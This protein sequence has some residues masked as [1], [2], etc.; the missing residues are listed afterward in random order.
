MDQGIQFLLLLVNV[1]SV[2]DSPLG[3][4]IQFL[5]LLANAGSVTDSPLGSGYPVFTLTR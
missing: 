5:L 1:V 3:S 4:G 2:T